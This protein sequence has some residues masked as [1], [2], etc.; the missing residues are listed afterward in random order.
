MA[1]TKRDYY[2][3]LGV[4]RSA[5][6]DE[7]RRAYRRL[8]LQYHPDRNPS[9]DASEKF[10]EAQEAYEV[11]S[12]P[13]RRA[14]YDRFGHLGE[15]GFGGLGANGFGIEDIFE[16]FFGAAAGTG[17]RQR[18]QRGADLRLDLQLSF[19]ESIFGTEKDVTVPKHETCERCNGRGIEPGSTP[20][21]CPTCGGTGEIRRAH[22]SIFGQFV[23]VSV[24][25]R[26]RGEGQL[27]FDPCTE[28][29]GQ[30]VVR[31]QKTLRVTVPAGV[32]DGTQLRL[33]GEGEPGPNGGPPGHLYVVLHVQP[34]RFFRRQG[35]DLLLELPI[36]VAQAALGAEVEVPL[37]EGDTVPLDIPAGT[38]SGRVLRIRGKGV[39]VL[40]G[41]GRGDLLV[42]VKVMVPTELTREQRELFRKLAATFGDEVS[43]QENK[44]FFEK[45]K[46]AFGV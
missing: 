6:A 30:G 45:V 35:N 18:V 3:V 26:C 10:K 44:G 16:S 36:N 8:A 37:L 13:E 41:S 25:S 7:I 46:D 14:Q 11:L 40:Q 15:G 9:A 19:E 39:P 24:C 38:Q 23:N 42:R 27:V 4:G 12:D 22:Q 31:R 17:R 43:P 2:E 33:S 34:H 5:S 32:S 28:C 20:V 29:H 21:P 1:T